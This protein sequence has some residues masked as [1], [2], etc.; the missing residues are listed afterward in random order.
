MSETWV[1]LTADQKAKL[2]TYMQST[3]NCQTF[4]AA[5]WDKFFCDMEIEKLS[6]G[7]EYQYIYFSTP[8]YLALNFAAAFGAFIGVFGLTYLLPALLNRYWLWLRK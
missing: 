1:P 8:K 6:A 2:S 5:F 3:K 4:E 7:G